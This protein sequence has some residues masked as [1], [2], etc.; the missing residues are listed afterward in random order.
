MGMHLGQATHVGGTMAL[1][2]WDMEH[3][4]LS[5]STPPHPCWRALMV[6]SHWLQLA[7]AKL[8]HSMAGMGHGQPTSSASNHP[9]DEIH[10]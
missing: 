4:I 1:R 10:G 2:V 3:F 6:G 8:S 9:Q 7:H 5:I